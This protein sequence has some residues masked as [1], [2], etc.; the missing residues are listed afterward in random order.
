MMSEREKELL[1]KYKLTEYTLGLLVA[2]KEKNLLRI[3]QNLISLKYLDNK[4]FLTKDG[5][6][7]VEEYTKTEFKYSEQEMEELVQN[8]RAMYPTGIKPGSN[9]PWRGTPKEVL[10]KLYSVMKQHADID[11]EDVIIA[12]RKYL[13]TGESSYRRTLPYFIEKNGESDM[14]NFIL[15]MKEQSQETP[16]LPF[17]D[18]NNDDDDGGRWL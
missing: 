16:D 2:N 10:K 5:E 15:T 18:D 7:I 1:D 11:K 14:Y 4:G 3:I 17:L 13:I 12:V 8:I 9:K 6:A